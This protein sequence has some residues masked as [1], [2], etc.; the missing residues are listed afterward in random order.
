MTSE[1]GKSICQITPF[2]YPYPGGQEV[3]T[4]MLSRSLARIGW[5]V[6]IVTTNFPIGK[7][8]EKVDG[9]EI[10]RTRMVI[11]PIDNPITPSMLSILKKIDAD[12]FHAHSYWNFSTNVACFISQLRKIPFLITSHGYQPFRYFLGKFLRTFY[13]KTIGGYTLSNLDKMI[14][15]HPQDKHILMSLGV[16]EA[17]IEIIPNAITL[18]EF[19]PD[20]DGSDFIEKYNLV[21]SKRILFVGRLIKRKGC[22]YI[23][24]AMKDILRVFP[25][26]KLIV[27]GNGPQERQLKSLSKNLKISESVI[28]MGYIPPLGET[29]KKIYAISDVLVLPSL[30]ECMSR[31]ILEAMSMK[32]PIITTDAWYSKWLVQPG[33]VAAV[34]VNPKITE[35]L[36]NAVISVLQDSALATNLATKGRKLIEDKYNW[37]KIAKQLTKLYVKCIEGKRQQLNL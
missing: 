14:L 33:E 21:E 19:N 4:Y 29:L 35:Q 15:Y 11:N 26:A 18:E 24:K 34:L 16:P 20:I 25:N 36:A 1:K 28:F 27:V 8:Y 13:L 7:T 9:V 5:K 17:K 37:D 10:Y 32:K 12:V 23:I 2:L 6:S 22:K 30:D 3:H 31:V